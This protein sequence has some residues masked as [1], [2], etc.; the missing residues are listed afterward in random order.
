MTEV[1]LVESIR[2]VVR[3]E[4][5]AHVAT[6]GREYLTVAE[7]A[8]LA[9]GGQSIIRN[10]FKDGTLKRHGTPGRVLVSRGELLAV[11]ERSPAHV[12]SE[13]AIEALAA[14]FVGGGT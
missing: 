4:L 2:K 13:E 10:W 11:L 9:R 6:D 8:A 5:R 3:E 14:S 1:E 7:A 12:T